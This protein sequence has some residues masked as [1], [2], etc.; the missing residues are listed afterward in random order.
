MLV[1]YS[2]KKR[3]VARQGIAYRDEQRE[4][5]Q[6]IRRDLTEY[7]SCQSGSIL[8]FRL[9]F[10]VSR[11]GGLRRAVLDGGVLRRGLFARR[12]RFIHNILLGLWIRAARHGFSFLIF[13]LI[14]GGLPSSAFIG[15][16]PLMQRTVNKI[17]P[18][19]QN[20]AKTA[21]ELTNNEII[22]PL[23]AGNVNRFF[24]KMRF[25]PCPGVNDK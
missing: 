3:L 19:S 16:S 1:F 25:S 15:L 7:L 10:P 6:Q 9:C 24:V 18:F 23:F 22:I 11:R 5:A 13:D 17:G 12:G 4:A 8:L 21:R 14:C 20:A 2:N